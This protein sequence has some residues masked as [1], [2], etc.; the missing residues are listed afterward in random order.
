VGIDC[1]FYIIYKVTI[2]KQKE[3]NHSQVHDACVRVF[4]DNGRNK[5]TKHT[6]LEIRQAWPSKV[7]NRVQVLSEFV[8]ESFSFAKV[9]VIV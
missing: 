9:F 4:R 5:I 1:S 6:S 7:H 2:Q 8:K 3:Q